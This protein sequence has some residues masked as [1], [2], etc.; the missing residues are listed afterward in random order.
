[1]RLKLSEG[2]DKAHAHATTTVANAPAM[3]EAA[4]L[5]VRRK[6]RRGMCHHTQ[7]LR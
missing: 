5:A 7:E 2:L 4:S 6:A 3:R 1:M